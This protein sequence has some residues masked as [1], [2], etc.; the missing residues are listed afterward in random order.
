VQKTAPK[1]DQWGRGAD[2]HLPGPVKGQ[3]VQKKGGNQ[4]TG[5]NLGGRLEG[6][7]E[8]GSKKLANKHACGSGLLLKY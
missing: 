3:V 5:A 2:C 1:C 4:N 6:R 8:K 7:S